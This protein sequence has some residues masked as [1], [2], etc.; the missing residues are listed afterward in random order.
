MVKNLILVLIT[1]IVM[2]LIAR[3][4]VPNNWIELFIKGAVVGLICTIEFFVV[5]FKT[6]GA[7]SIILRIK[8]IVLRKGE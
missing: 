7:Q 1:I 3:N 5:Y 6:P 2:Y 8:S 4:F